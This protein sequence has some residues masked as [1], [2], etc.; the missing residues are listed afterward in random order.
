M[1][2]SIAHSELQLFQ[3]RVVAHQVQSVENI[4]PLLQTQKTSFLHLLK[5]HK[6]NGSDPGEV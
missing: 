3:E 1:K 4:V 6:Q 5:G 2:V